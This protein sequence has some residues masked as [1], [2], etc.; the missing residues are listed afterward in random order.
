MEISIE[1]I[2]K[3]KVWNLEFKIFEILMEKVH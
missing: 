3:S 2:P 1:E